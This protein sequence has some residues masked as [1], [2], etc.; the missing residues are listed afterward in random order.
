MTHA[1]CFSDE[2]LELLKD[3]EAR[4]I[5]EEEAVLASFSAAIETAM[6]KAGVTQ[7]E[8]AA[9]AGKTPQA[10][11]RALR[12]SQNL[13]VGTMLDLAFALGCTLNL[14][15]VP[16][17]ELLPMGTGNSEPISFQVHHRKP[18]SVKLD[19]PPFDPSAPPTLTWAV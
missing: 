19:D 2:Y 9:K 8:L 7:K 11:C 5:F 13:T 18:Q 16:L 12:G 6:K 1:T 3:P 15:V 14:E 17:A 10:V 4:R